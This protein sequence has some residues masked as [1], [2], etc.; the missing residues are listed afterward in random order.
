MIGAQL[1]ATS[2]V[3]FQTGQSEGNFY[4]SPY[5]TDSVAHLSGFVMLANEKADPATQVY[6]SHGWENYR[7]ARP[8]QPKKT[9]WAYVKMQPTRPNVV[10]GDLYVFEEAEIIAVV[11]GS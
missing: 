4:R 1:K 3:D 5:W 10:V 6:V 8:F 9:Y 7:V 2:S 11:E